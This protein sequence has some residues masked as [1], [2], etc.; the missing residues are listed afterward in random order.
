MLQLGVLVKGGHRL[1]QER[2]IEPAN[3]EVSDPSEWRK[4]KDLAL[5]GMEL[6]IARDGRDAVNPVYGSFPK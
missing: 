4:Y 2:T 5:S 1:S 3:I 6:D